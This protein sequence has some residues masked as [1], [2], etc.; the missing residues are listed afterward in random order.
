MT[1]ILIEDSTLREGEQTPGVAFSESQKRSILEGLAKA[2][3]KYAEVGIPVMGSVEFKAIQA[4]AKDPH[5][6]KLIG[7]NRGVKSDVERTFEAGLTALHIGLPSSDVHIKEK[8]K[9][10][11]NWVIET[12]V[13]LIEFAKSQGATFISVSAE[14][15]GRAN[16]DFL[17]KY[18]KAVEK[19]GATRMRLSD[20]VGCLTPSKVKEIVT[21]LTREVSNLNFQLHMHNDFNLA[22]ANVISGLEAGAKQVHVTINGLGDRAGIA[23]LHQVVTALEVLTDYTTDVNLLE[24]YN[25]SK[26]VEQYTNL[27]ISHNEPVVGELVFAHES[28]IHVDGMLKVK[29]SFEAFAPELVGRSNTFIIGKHTGSRAIQHVLQE[30]GLHVSREEA[31]E[32]IPF[33]REF[34]TMTKSSIEPELLSLFARSILKKNVAVEV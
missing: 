1:N 29:H 17:K 15:M 23:A 18:V 22:L 27:H 9:R 6:P 2:N 20:T 5:L 33:V 24:I 11:Y 8:F 21:T 10:D 31:Q 7:W 25:L 12:A 19:A 30:Q 34:S 13:E 14:D 3:I 16:M 32:I 26:L 4:L 28:G